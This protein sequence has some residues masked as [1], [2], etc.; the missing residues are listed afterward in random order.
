MKQIQ[1]T[2]TALCGA[3]LMFT[4][5][6]CGSLAGNGFNYE[7]ACQNISINGKQYV[8]PF[9]VNELGD[10]YTLGG[11]TTP[12]LEED[13]NYT[14]M[15]SLYY[16]GTE[17][18]T[19]KYTGVSVADKDNAAA[20]N[21]K[22]IDV[23]SQNPLLMGEIE[24]PIGVNGIFVGDEQTKLS[25]TFGEPTEIKSAGAGKES[26]IY[27]D[28]GDSSI[29]WTVENSLVSSLLIIEKDS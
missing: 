12:K 2:V 7:E 16:K 24:I 19:V 15:K 29:R 11:V 20:Y 14:V 3:V 25:E 23:I 27:S 5:T 28:G 9:S 13:G 1:K 18:A 17:L 10:G 8:F 6:A 26:Y 22:K 21:D 4:A